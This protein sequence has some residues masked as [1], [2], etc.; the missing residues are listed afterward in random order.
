L[1]KKISNLN[2]SAYRDTLFTARASIQR[3]TC[4]FLTKQILYA[5]FHNTFATEHSLSAA[6]GITMYY[7]V[8]PLSL[9]TCRIYIC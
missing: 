9:V 7:V 5:V 4:S 6:T 3:H 1:P 2:N 8:V